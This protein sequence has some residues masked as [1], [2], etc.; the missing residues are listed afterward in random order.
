MGCLKT[1]I[2][3]VFSNRY[4]LSWQKSCHIYW[5]FLRGETEEDSA[6]MR[7]YT[8]IHLVGML[9]LRLFDDGDV[10]HR[11]C[12]I[13][14]NHPCPDFLFYKFRLIC[15]EIAEPD[16][17]FEFTKWGFDS[18]PG[19]IQLFKA[20]GWKLITRKIC[21]KTFICP[22]WELEPGYSKRKRI[23][24]FRS[25]FEKIKG[26]ICINI[27]A[28]SISAVNTGRIASY[29]GDI[30]RNVEA[31]L[32]WKGKLSNESFLVDVFC[33]KKKNCPLLMTWAIL[34]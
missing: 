30:N 11:L 5:I 9:S 7:S 31:L 24:F 10:Y 14:S 27:A 2:L 4:Q 28:V 22:F 15:M 34:L 16:C 23:G 13:I 26:S 18:P 17:I 32:L 3:P 1:I 8:K 6:Y 29:K 25:I 12:Q 20:L 19:K 21:N 33:T